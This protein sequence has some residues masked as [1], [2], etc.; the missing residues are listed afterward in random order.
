MNKILTKIIFIKIYLLSRY[1]VT[2]VSCL[3]GTL[4]TINPNYLLSVD[5]EY[6]IFS[7]K[8]FILTANLAN[9]IL[10][11]SLLSRY[12]F[13]LIFGFVSFVLF[14]VWVYFD[15][16]IS[17]LFYWLKLIDDVLLL[18]F[19]LLFVCFLIYR[20]FFII[21][22]VVIV[23]FVIIVI[24]ADHLTL[25]CYSVT[26]R[27]IFFYPKVIGFFSTVRSIFCGV[28]RFTSFEL[29]FWIFI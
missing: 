3:K 8:N 5:D 9:L 12:W 10:F 20:I 19:W 21:I 4:L 14:F 16:F 24:Q 15:F 18:L 23:I 7:T 22:V 25:I 28:N 6:C 13:L 27:F 1:H 26:F 29:L 17:W 11:C 2:F